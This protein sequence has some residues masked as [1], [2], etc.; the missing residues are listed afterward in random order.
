MSCSSSAGPRLNSLS[1]SSSIDLHK[2]CYGNEGKGSL[3]HVSTPFVVG[4]AH[5]FAIDRYYRPDRSHGL[6]ALL[7]ARL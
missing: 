5:V 3:R 1:S 7:F 4:V 2:R 6:S